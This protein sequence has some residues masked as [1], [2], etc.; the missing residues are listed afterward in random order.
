MDFKEFEE[1][2]LTLHPNARFKVDSPSN[3]CPVYHFLS[4]KGIAVDHVGYKKYDIGDKEESLPEIFTTFISEFDKDRFIR[5][6][7]P[8]K[9]LNA[10]KA[11]NEQ[12]SNR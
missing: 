3:S 4:R 12:I 1:W 2:L 10:I 8:K 6:W 11:V 7:S 5:F 9:A